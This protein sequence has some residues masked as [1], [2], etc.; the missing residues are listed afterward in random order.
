MINKIK[1][2]SKAL[3]WILSFLVVASALS[4]RLTKQREAGLE[5]DYLNAQA[6]FEKLQKGDS[7]SFSQLFDVCKRR[8]NLR[9]A[10][11]PAMAAHLIAQKRL[12][13]ARPFLPAPSKGWHGRYAQTSLVIAE[14]EYVG[15]LAEAQALHEELLKSGS[16]HTALL[17]A[18]NLVRIATLER[19]V[20]TKEGELKAL[21]T[22]DRLD[23]TV[24]SSLF[25]L[26]SEQDASLKEYLSYR[27]RTLTRPRGD[28]T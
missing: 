19:K 12:E 21:Q 9:S 6:A 15:A 25:S 22:F 16:D 23:N 5:R 4:Y 7:A 14:Q 10:F 17:L 13:E 2:H 8:T 28:A 20:G 11:A 26:I 1:E 3:T 24:K 27:M 18:F